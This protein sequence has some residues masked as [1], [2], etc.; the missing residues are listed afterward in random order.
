METINQNSLFLIVLHIFL[1]AGA[2]GGGGTLILDPNGE[3]SHLPLS[4]LYGLLVSIYLLTVM[5]LFLF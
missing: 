1:V 5:I 4:L 3:L 2:L